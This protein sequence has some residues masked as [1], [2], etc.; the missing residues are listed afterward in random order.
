MKESVQNGLASTSVAGKMYL[1]ELQWFKAFPRSQ[2]KF[3]Q[4]TKRIEMNT[5]STF[6]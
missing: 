1:K 5:K 6:K 4:K 3:E 2:N